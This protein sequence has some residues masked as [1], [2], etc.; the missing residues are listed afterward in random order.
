[1][2]GLR[3]PQKTDSMSRI[4]VFTVNHQPQGLHTSP[5]AR[6]EGLRVACADVRTHHEGLRVA[7]ADVRTHH[8]GL[9]IACADVHSLC[10]ELR[11]A[12][13]DVRPLSDNH[14]IP[15]VSLF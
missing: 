12:C 3:L 10:E 4:D 7:C 13:A 9:R 1:M 6:S 15:I 14:F 8:E 11:G 2:H 5:G